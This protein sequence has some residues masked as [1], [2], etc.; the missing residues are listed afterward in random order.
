[1]LNPIKRTFSFRDVS[2]SQNLLAECLKEGRFEWEH[3]TLQT[4]LPAGFS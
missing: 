2:A 3:N 1:M 4:A